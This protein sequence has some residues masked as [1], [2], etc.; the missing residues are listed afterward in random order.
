MSHLTEW[1][2]TFPSN[3]GDSQAL[4]GI[5]FSRYGLS[6]RNCKDKIVP[7]DAKCDSYKHVPAI[8]NLSW[9]SLKW[10]AKRQQKGQTS[11]DQ[12]GEATLLSVPPLWSGFHVSNSWKSNGRM[13]SRIIANSSRSPSSKAGHSIEQQIIGLHKAA[14]FGQRE[15]KSLQDDELEDEFGEHEEDDGHD[16]VPEFEE[17]EILEE[18]AGDSERDTHNRGQADFFDENI[19]FFTQEIPP[20]VQIKLQQIVNASGAGPGLR[21]LDVGAGT[22]ALTPYLYT[23]GVSDITAVD[24]SIMMLA[25]LKEKYDEVRCWHGDVADLPDEFGPFDIVFFNAMFGNV[26]EPLETLKAAARL[27]KPG[28]TIVISH[29]LG[30]AFVEKLRSASPLVVPRG[31]P[32]SQQLQELVAGTDGQLQLVELRDEPHYYLARLEVTRS[33]ATDRSSSGEGAVS[34]EEQKREV[35]SSQKET[36]PS[37]NQEEKPV[38]L[39][40]PLFMEG[41]VIAGFGRGSRQMG[42]PTA[43]LP[44]EKV[45]PLLEGL[46]RGVY[47]G[48]AQVPSLDPGVHAMVMNVGKRPTFVDGD[49]LSVEVHVLHKFAEDFYGQQMRVAVL[50]FLRPERAFASLDELVSTIHANIETART[51]L[52]K[53]A[54]APARRDSFFQLNEAIAKKQ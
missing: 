33:D 10:S 19:S 29:P 18:G 12:G 14:G 46:E 3:L 27:S 23:A 32:D 24:L 9:A 44:P 39:E 54:N 17:E 25:E 49:G 20:D 45:G 30:A 15:Q 42:V 38:L 37:G 34:E 1:A 43:N 11:E 53:E 52:E 2:E 51:E 16:F 35:P 8:R 6:S 31:L 26:Y 22:G 13:S 50:G 28:A 47:Y 4:L 36:E 40:N 21:V 5:S 7:H 48:W 41:E